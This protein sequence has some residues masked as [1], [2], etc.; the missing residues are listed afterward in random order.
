MVTNISFQII[1]LITSI[2]LLLIWIKQKK[3]GLFNESLIFISII[4][5]FFFQLFDLLSRLFILLNINNLISLIFSKL[6]ISFMIFETV[7]IVAYFIYQSKEG[8]NQ[9]TIKA[10][11]IIAGVLL[12]LFIAIFDIKYAYNDGIVSIQGT[13]ILI[14]YCICWVIEVA[15]LLFGLVKKNSL[16]TLQKAALIVW[17]FIMILGSVVSYIWPQISCMGLSCSLALIGIISIAEDIESYFNIALECFHLDAF[18]EF[19]KL[20]FVSKKPLSLLYLYI[21]NK[22]NEYRREAIISNSIDGAIGLCKKTADTKIFKT[23]SNACVICSNNTNELIEMANTIKNYFDDYEL[24]VNYDN[25][26]SSSIV[27]VEDI[28]LAHSA[29]DLMNLLSS[30]KDQ[31]ENDPLN[32][33]IIKIE[34]SLIQKMHDELELLKEIDYALANDGVVLNYQPVYSVNKG[35]ITSVEVLTRLKTS[36][37]EILLPNKFIPTAEK[38]GRI[39]ELGEKILEKSCIFYN[40]MADKGIKLED[41]SINFSSYQL[42]DPAII[43]SVIDAVS[44]NGL[45]PSSLC[46][47]VTNATSIRRRKEY[48]KNIDKLVSFGISLALTGYGSDNSNLEYITNMP[49]DL[50]RL[51]RNFVWRCVDEPKAG[52]MLE[53]VVELIHKFRMKTIAVGI[54]NQEQSEKLISYGVDYLQGLFIGKPMSE[55]TFVEYIRNKEGNIE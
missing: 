16:N 48:L 52:I 5:C 37:N 28:H 44:N 39:V 8:R 19:I 31:G 29:L 6:A 23:Q 42:E 50:I 15:L 49:A 9:K 4:F 1:G 11:C 13:S 3:I 36:T 17:A 46:I 53:N 38:Y 7:S 51:D 14:A 35:K 10:V 18:M 22:D 43:N 21:F 30:S 34:S 27:F 2:T 12:A 20:K 26:V 41:I 54:E 47:E 45:N 55:D 33:S 32:A 25:R 40:T 24:Q